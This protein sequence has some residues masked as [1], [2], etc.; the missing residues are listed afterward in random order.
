MRSRISAGNLAQA[1]GADSDEPDAKADHVVRLTPIGDESEE[2]PN[3][4]SPEFQLDYSSRLRVFDDSGEIEKS[5]SLVDWQ[6]LVRAC[7]RIDGAL[8]IIRHRDN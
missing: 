2:Q 1:G 4:L 7:R 8:W 3:I 5:E 6:A